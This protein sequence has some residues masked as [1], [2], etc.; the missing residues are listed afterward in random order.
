MELPEESE[1]QENEVADELQA[2]QTRVRERIK[3]AIALLERAA[4]ALGSESELYMGTRAMVYGN[5]GGHRL[6]HAG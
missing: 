5:A 1:R 3:E 2:E 6:R 4:V